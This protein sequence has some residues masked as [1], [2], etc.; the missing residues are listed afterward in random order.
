M[1]GVLLDPVLGTPVGHDAMP[2]RDEVRELLERRAA[3]DPRFRRVTVFLDR[4]ERARAGLGLN[5][6]MAA[7]GLFYRD[8]RPPFMVADQTAIT[9]A[10]EALA[11]PAFYSS[12]PL[13]YFGQVAKSL[14][15]IAYGKITT[16]ASS[17]GNITVTP[18]YGT[19]TGG[20]SLL[21][22]TATALV[23]SATNIPWRLELYVVCRAIGTSGALFSEGKFETT[24]AV[25]ASPSTIFTPGSAPAQVTVDTTAAQGIVVGITLGSATDTLTTQILDVESLN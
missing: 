20:T 23:A 2:W 1:R 9:G 5:R 14:R 6:P 21:A 8:T 25:I 13:N 15:I 19:T 12:L 24:T 22:S 16:A 3:D 10:S 18:R 17:Q 7:D 11:W 4:D